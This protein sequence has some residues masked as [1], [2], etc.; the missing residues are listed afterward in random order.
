MNEVEWD[1]ERNEGESSA[2]LW[3]TP[4]FPISRGLCSFGNY[5]QAHVKDI[6]WWLFTADTSFSHLLCSR[7][8]IES[9]CWGEA[10]SVQGPPVWLEM[11]WEGG[12]GRSEGGIK[13]LFLD[14]CCCS[15]CIWALETYLLNRRV[16][17]SCCWKYRCFLQDAHQFQIF[18]I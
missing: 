5:F 9:L 17:P 8:Y 2:L 14:L 7:V 1:T 4:V 3:I 12:R 10:M 13:Q 6:P 16:G 18:S 11:R 15:A